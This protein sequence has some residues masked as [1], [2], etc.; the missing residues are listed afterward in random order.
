VRKTK[1]EVIGLTFQERMQGH[2]ASVAPRQRAGWVSELR[3]EVRSEDRGLSRASLD[4]WHA[5]FATAELKGIRNANEERADLADDFARD[6][7]IA[8]ELDA[9]IDDLSAFLDREYS[10]KP[11]DPGVTIELS[12][13]VFFG[14]DARPYDAAAGRD[15]REKHPITHATLQLF[16]AARAK[17]RKALEYVLTFQYRGKPY[18]L[19]G[20]KVIEDDPRL[21]V[22]H[23]ASTLNFDIEDLTAG[24]KKWRGVLRLPAAE[25]L[26]AQVKSFDVTGT[27][28]PDRKMWALGAF[29]AFFSG[30]LVDSYVPELKNLP[31]L[32]RNLL[33]RTH[34]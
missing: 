22:W 26:E 4:R 34:G 28:D 8:V 16:R 29:L 10:R 13:N 31:A 3:A 19:H 6:G 32:L 1:A 12:G 27:D 30:H 11:A 33:L 18:R 24:E 9:K 5:G 23:D 25:F 14:K 17:R 15:T 2:Y 7:E 21:D 20:L